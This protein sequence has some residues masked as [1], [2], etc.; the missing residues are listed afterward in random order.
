MGNDTDVA[1]GTELV[2]RAC[3]IVEQHRGRASA[4]AAARCEA[5][6]L[7]DA[8]RETSLTCPD[9][10]VSADLEGAAAEL[11]ALV[12]RLDDHRRPALTG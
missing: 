10:A 9:L 11:D 8:L 3:D 6:L 12:A 4:D 2:T 7:R 5:V 1:M